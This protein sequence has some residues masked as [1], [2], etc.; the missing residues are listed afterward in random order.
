[1]AVVYTAG[2]L[3]SDIKDIVSRTDIVIVPVLP[4]PNDV[5]PFTRTVRG[6]QKNTDE[7]IVIVVNR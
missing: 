2:V 5:E 4:S 7:P 3:T 1:M 6:V